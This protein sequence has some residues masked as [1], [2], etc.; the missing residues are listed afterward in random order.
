MQDLKT[1]YILRASPRAQFFVQLIGS[2]FSVVFA[3]AAWYL[4]TSAYTIPGP[5]FAVPS[6]TLWLDMSEFLTQPDAKLP[7][8][9]TWFCVVGGIL[10]GALPILEKLRP[11]WSPYL[12]SAVAF[13][14]GMYL[15][16]SWT[17]PRF[18]G[19]V[20][21]TTWLKL[22]PRSHNRSMIIVASGLVLGEGILSIVTA[23]L[24]SAHVPVATCFGCSSLLCS[25]CLNSTRIF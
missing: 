21:Q 17:I 24:T 25:G 22:W 16:P 7:R 14:I 18:I 19:S 3:M 2:L 10:A 5:E 11:T 4:Y 13:A 15:T 12:P 23:G 9:L 6:A 1:G 8:N 20:V